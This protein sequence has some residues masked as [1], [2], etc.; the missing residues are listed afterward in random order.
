M[1]NFYATI[2][3]PHFL[4]DHIRQIDRR[5]V[6][7]G[8]TSGCFDLFHAGHA[9]LLRRASRRYQILIVAV[10]SDETVRRLKGVDRPIYSADQRV[11]IVASI[12]GV[13]YVTIFEEGTPEAL[14]E[15]IRP[16]VYYKGG[17]YS[18][19]DMPEANRVRSWGGK[20]TIIPLLPECSTTET[21]RKIRNGRSKDPI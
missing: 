3:P 6:Q 2:I 7:I 10:N 15:E 21:V 4:A 14:L 1:N 20:I 17:D 12:S 13:D 5:D 9:H 19:D 16:D 11:Q 18:I 8:F